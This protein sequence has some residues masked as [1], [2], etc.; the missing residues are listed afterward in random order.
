M[1]TEFFFRIAGP[2]IFISALAFFNTWYSSST[3]YLSTTK[4]MYTQDG[5]YEERAS[6]VS[7]DESVVGRDELK[8]MLMVSPDRDIVISDAVSGYTL[9]IRSG[10]M[11]NNSVKIT[12][13]S[14][15]R[16]IF[17]GVDRWDP[18]ALDLDTWLQ[19]GEYRSKAITHSTG[20]IRRI[21]YKSE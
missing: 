21:Y 15:S 9:T 20:A 8:A 6:L 3:E 11:V 4:Q 2:A 7:G 14:G 19:A 5:V 13:P 18:G 12:S 10:R 16:T 17:F 1:I